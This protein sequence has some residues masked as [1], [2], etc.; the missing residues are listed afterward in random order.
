MKYIFYLEY[1][2]NWGEEV[3][4]LGNTEQLG[5][6]IS[7]KALPMSTHDGVNWQL[8]LDIKSENQISYHYLITCHG[9]VMREEPLYFN[10]I[11][12]ETTNKLTLIHDRWFDKPN[13]S[14]QY[15]S[16]FTNVWKQQK[17]KDTKS[18]ESG[19]QLS[20]FC[21]A[22]ST[23]QTLA[24]LGNHDQLGN[25]DHKKALILNGNHSPFWSGSI[26]FEELHYDGDLI[27]KYV[28][29]NKKTKEIVAW[30]DGENR[31]FSMQQLDYNAHHIQVDS[32]PE[33]IQSKWKAAGLAVP[34]FSL[35][36]KNSCG[37]GEFTD[38][39]LLVDWAVRCKLKLVQLLP[40]NDTTL[41]NTWDDSYPY[42]CTSVFALNPIY[43]NLEQI[44]INNTKFAKEYQSIKVNCNELNTIDFPTVQSQKQVFTRELFNVYGK[45]T[46]ASEDYT[47]FFNMNKGWLVPYAIYL[48]LRGI[49]NSANTKLWKE[50]T[51]F[52]DQV[53]SEFS[54]VDH[55]A[56]EDLEYIYF[57]QYHLYKQLKEASIYAQSK[58]VVLKGDLPIGIGLHS[59]DAWV[60][61]RYFNIDCQAGAPPD[62]FAQ[63]GQNWGFP[64]YNWDEIEK[65]D[66]LWWKMRLSYMANFF[67]AYRI[68]HILGFFRIWTIPRTALDGTLGQFAPALPYT[69]EQLLQLGFIF[70]DELYTN[71]YISAAQLEN[72]KLTTTQKKA[73]F[74]QNKDGLYR[75]KENVN[76][77]AKLN[78]FFESD[79]A[80]NI[81][82]ITKTALFRLHTEVL[83]LEDINQKGLYHPRID[84]Y[85]TTIYK[86]LPED[87]KA[88]FNKI[89]HDFF[90]VKHNDYWKKEALV[91]L[92]KL[93]QSSRML[94][95]GE[96]LGMI[97]QSVPE[98]MKSLDILRL[99][100]ERMPKSEG[101]VIDNPQLY[102]H[103]SVSAFSTHDMSTL[104]GW[105]EENR[106][107]ATLL[108]NEIYRNKENIPQ[109]LSPEIAY[110]IL[111]RELCGRSMLCIQALQDWLS[112]T[113]RWYNQIAPSNEQIN[114]PA[115]IHNHWKYRMPGTLEDLIKDK[116]LIEAIDSLLSNS[117]RN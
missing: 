75:F 89:Y 32:R 39:K 85:K 36:S 109:K 114:V 33:F 96:D 11:L 77:Q 71:P 98:V 108:F 102:P 30:E 52:S 47:T 26:S 61:A 112:L 16:A 117:E 15:S 65:D 44:G 45:D 73:L 80:K 97:P 95:C 70:D 67:Q 40:V 68:D 86:T 53:I 107:Q 60:Y 21:S 57:V 62:D 66:F 54:W 27:Y 9:K 51:V 3:K 18:L 106:E 23:D 84:A 8:T 28:I 49:Y 59:A 43:L 87:K 69:R 72:I 94:V 17:Q 10:R 34:V 63:D 88:V 74:T 42:R 20:T 19:L 55:P 81:D 41:T 116:R 2:T 90:Y 38:I 103:Q 113:D 31:I 22:V 92:P 14:P 37:I 76:N 99:E 13:N 101:L 104:R 48:Y 24:I 93:I 83:F 110:A 115:N 79:K 7:S 50:H 78:Q 56:K 82:S 100:I 105:W 46:F 1:H 58:G 12:I 91:K 35:R 111:N 25:W 29:L 6:N 4:L 64:T 5:S